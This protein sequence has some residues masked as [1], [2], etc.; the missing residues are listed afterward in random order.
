MEVSHARQHSAKALALVAERQ[1]ST[2]RSTQRR[3]AS[4][5]RVIAPDMIET[6]DGVR[7]HWKEIGRGR[8]ILF[9]S[10]WAMSVRMWD[11]Q[12]AAFADHGFRC[13]AFDRRGHGRSDQ[14]A[15]G[16]DSDTFADDVAA[17]IEALDLRDLT[18]VGHSM[19]GGEIVRYLT[20]HGAG[21]IGRAVLIAPTTPFLLKTEDNPNGLPG[22]FFDLTWAA[23]KQDFPKWVA[24]NTAPFFT[25]ET[26]PAMAQW[27]VNIL[28]E[29]SVPVAL[30]TSRGFVP[31]DFREEMKAIDLP[32][33]ILHGDRDASAPLAL[34]GEASA[35]LIPGAKLKIYEG[36]PHGLMYTH[37]DELNRDILAFIEET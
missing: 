7:L 28:L 37:R 25:P 22:E 17:V 3:S 33:L 21:R 23:W 32:V 29:I 1:P 30:A 36:G 2:E 18:L 8:P 10:S 20:R 13:I 35:A 31:T 24:D 5:G 12:I 16:Y 15:E 27:G 26:S 11:F 34:T 6:A 14:P 4:A 9:V 19:A